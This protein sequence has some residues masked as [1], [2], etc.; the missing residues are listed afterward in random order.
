MKLKKKKRSTT[1]S[2]IIRHI[3]LA[4]LAAAL[5]EFLLLPGQLR[6]MQTL[7]GLAAMSFPRLLTVTAIGALV[8]WGIST[9]LST[10]IYQRW[11]AVAVFGLLAVLALTA[12][13]STAFLVICLLVLAV[14][15]VYT[16]WGHDKSEVPP[17]PAQKVHWGYLVAVALLAVAFFVMVCVWTIGRYRTFSTP[18][19]DFGIFAQMFYSMKETGLPMTTVERDG[20]LSHFAVHVSPIYY[21]MLPFYCL[22]PD[23]ATLQ[24]LQAAVLASAVIPLWLIGK[25]HGLSGPVRL[26]LCALLLLLPV[27][28][29]GTS[30]D[31]HENCFLLPLILWLMYAID[32]RSSLLTA[33]FALLT[34]M[35]KED[36]AVYVAVAG[37][38]LLV[39]TAVSGQTDKRRDLITGAAVVA[40]AVVWFLLV[41]SYLAN[42]GDGV[43]TTRYRNFMYDGSNSLVTVIK[44]VLLSPMK[45]LFECV[46]AEKLKYIGQTMLPLLGLPLLTRKFERYLLLIPYILVNLMSDYTYQHDVLFQYNFGSTAF[47]IYLAAVNIRDLKLQIPQLAAL[48]AAVAVSIGFFNSVIVP[49]VEYYGGLYSKHQA[50][51]DGVRQALDTIPEG[52]TVTTHTFYGAYLSEREVLYDIRYCTKEHLLSTEFVVLKKS[53]TSEFKKYEVDGKNGYENLIALLEENGYLPYHNYQTSVVIYCKP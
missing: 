31:I 44:A 50:Y 17:Q 23:P 21:L 30:Y 36:A 9:R 18:N 34:L 42:H 48:G 4:W 15:T 45:M 53:Y 49:K 20:L 32:S 22:F 38:Y 10:G 33:I 39:R 29:G 28:S 19:Y 51:Y 12:S 11:A 5:L 25:R 52:A 47:L 24:V 26:L 46:D 7:K 6:D 35:V 27:T 2:D 13:Y 41:T 37:I 40:G 43:M 1:A 14:L 16:V 8:L 3:F